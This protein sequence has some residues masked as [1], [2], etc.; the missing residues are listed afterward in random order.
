MFTLTVFVHMRH[1]DETAETAKNEPQ[2]IAESTASPA[3]QEAQQEPAEAAPQS[4]APVAARSPARSARRETAGAAYNSPPQES[5]RTSASPAA[6]GATEN[7]EASHEETAPAAEAFVDKGSTPDRTTAAYPPQPAIAA[8][9][10]KQ[11]HKAIAGAAQSHSY[12]AR[13]PAT[14]GTVTDAPESSSEQVTVSADRLEAQAQPAARF[15]KQKQPPSAAIVPGAMKAI[16]LPSGLRAESLA[17]TGSRK[18]AID[19][20]GALFLSEESG[21]TWEQVTRQWTGRAV[22]VRTE[23]SDSEAAGDSSSGTG[24]ASPPIAFFELLNDQSQIWLSID[25]KTWIA[26]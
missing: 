8:W 4:P 22:T 12:A 24:A 18:L 6:P 10:Q 23:T 7:P 25:G 16:L 15:A 13:E 19:T 17:A 3:Q 26:R 9:Q 14:G 21:D 20:A 11:R 2:E 5:V 1:V